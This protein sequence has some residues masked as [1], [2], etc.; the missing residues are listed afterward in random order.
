MRT[1]H[2]QKTYIWTQTKIDSSAD[3]FP[4]EFCNHI[5]SFSIIVNLYH[6]S[7]PWHFLLQKKKS[8][9]FQMDYYSET[10]IISTLFSLFRNNREFCSFSHIYSLTHENKI[11]MSFFS[12]EICL[13]IAF[14]FRISVT[15]FYCCLSISSH[16]FRCVLEL[17]FSFHFCFF[18]AIFR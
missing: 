2:R 5:G 3:T 4:F 9:I 14:L 6:F 17:F 1:A 10:I 13:S 18:V 16:F 7:T 15:S 11:I 8:T 12:V